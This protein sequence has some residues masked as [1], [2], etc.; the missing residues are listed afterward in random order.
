[1]VAITRCAMVTVQ[2]WFGWDL[3]ASSL[4]IFPER[5]SLDEVKGDPLSHE[6]AMHVLLLT[7]EYMYK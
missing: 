2:P 1:M 3:C 4:E 6:I 7:L 5:R